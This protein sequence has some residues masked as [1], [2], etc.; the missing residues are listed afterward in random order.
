MP[1]VPPS[2]A[3]RGSNACTSRGSKRI[4]SVGTYGTTA[5]STSTRCAKAG[6]SGSST[7]PSNTSTPFRRAHRAAPSSSSVARTC[8]EGTA[9]V[10]T[11]AI[12]PTPVQRSTATP[13]GGRSV[14]ARRA[15]GSVWLRGT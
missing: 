4:E 2:S 5:V 13:A 3:S 12:A 1:S 8:A 11:A 15:N 7:K 6:G 10:I 9:A 14:A